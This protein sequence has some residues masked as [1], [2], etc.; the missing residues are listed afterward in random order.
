MKKFLIIVLA[1]IIIIIV[2]TGA[3]ACQ[4]LQPAQSTTNG[5]VTTSTNGETAEAE[6]EPA[7]PVYY[8]VEFWWYHP[9]NI[10]KMC[11][12]QVEEGKVVGFNAPAKNPYDEGYYGW[13]TTETGAIEWN[14][15]LYPVTCDMRLYAHS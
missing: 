3:S 10:Y 5:Q 11:E 14:L 4:L 9:T 12:I 6:E 13:F 15:Y 8:T 2:A 7:E 1:I